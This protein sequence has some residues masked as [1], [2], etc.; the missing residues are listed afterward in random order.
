[1]LARA[2]SPPCS[3]LRRRTQPSSRLVREDAKWCDVWLER[4]QGL[5]VLARVRVHVR[6]SEYVCVRA[7]AQ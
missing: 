2:P 6:G 7:C 4:R 1:M 3:A 5:R